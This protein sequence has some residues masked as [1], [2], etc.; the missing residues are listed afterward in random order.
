VLAQ[1]ERVGIG[2]KLYQRTDRLS[3]GERQRVAIARA[4][5]QKPA[6]LFAD[7]P[8]SSVD[9]ARAR[10]TLELLTGISRERG[11]TLV[12]S[13][14]DTQLARAFLPRLVGLREGRILFDRRTSDLQDE[15]M[16][17]LYRLGE[18]ERGP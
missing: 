4:L 8:V 12:V 6:A 7:E 14:H 13:L 15:D 17:E 9:P 3:G 2:D 1:L 11:L 10:D 5:F 16:G 18:V